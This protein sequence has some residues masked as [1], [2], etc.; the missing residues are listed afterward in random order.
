MVFWLGVRKDGKDIINTK[1]IDDYSFNA[2]EY[3]SGEYYAWISAVNSCG[4][5]DSEGIRFSVRTD[6]LLGDVND[7]G[8]ID[9]K[10]VTFMRRALAGWDVTINEATADVNKDGSF[11]LKDVVVLRRYLAGGWGVEL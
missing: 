1:I 4:S 9:L 7:D 10:D 2:S 11:D 6:M 3:G 5:T 8:S